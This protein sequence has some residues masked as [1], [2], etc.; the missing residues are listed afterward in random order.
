MVRQHF[1]DL[2]AQQLGNFEAAVFWG[3]PGRRN[4]GRHF[5]HDRHRAK[6]LR[7]RLYS[8]HLWG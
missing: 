2:P 6:C 7:G 3:W 8:E 4:V 5:H 1:A